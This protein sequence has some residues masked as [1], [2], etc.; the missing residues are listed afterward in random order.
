MGGRS[1]TKRYLIY[2]LQLYLGGGFP[3][4][5]KKKVSYNDMISYC[6]IHILC[7]YREGENFKVHL[8]LS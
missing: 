5:L 3:I 6:H 2:V 7:N 4:T 1:F 8:P